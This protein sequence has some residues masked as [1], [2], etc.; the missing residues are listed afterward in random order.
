MN[1][2]VRPIKLVPNFPNFRYP[3]LED[4]V[5]GARLFTVTNVATDDGNVPYPDQLIQLNDDPIVVGDDRQSYVLF[6]Y[7][8]HLV[9]VGDDLCEVHGDAP[10]T[11]FLGATDP[12]EFG[13]DN[14]PQFWI[15]IEV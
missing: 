1:D 2:T 9:P 12:N 15:K 11:E 8:D 13:Q 5:V 14:T 10:L 4:L 6:H 3:E 7:V